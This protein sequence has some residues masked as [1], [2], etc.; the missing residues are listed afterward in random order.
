MLHVPTR[1]RLFPT[2]VQQLLDHPLDQPAANRLAP[3]QPQRIVQAS[4]MAR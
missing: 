3:P 1:S 2:L 4:L